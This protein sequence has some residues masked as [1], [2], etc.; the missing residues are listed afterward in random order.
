LQF[1]KHITIKTILKL[2][3]LSTS[4][5]GRAF[6][7]TLLEP[8]NMM[9]F[10]RITLIIF[11]TL[12]SFNLNAGDSTPAYT[13]I[14]LPDYRKTPCPNPDSQGK[15]SYNASGFQGTF[16]YGYFDPITGWGK[17][18][19]CKTPDGNPTYRMHGT[20]FRSDL[21]PP[22]HGFSF[23]GVINKNTDPSKK[24]DV[25]NEFSVF[26][27][28]DQ[29][30]NGNNEFGIVFQDNR[31]EGRFY[32]CKDCNIKKEYGQGKEGEEDLQKWFEW[33]DD[34]GWVD[35]P[36]C[37][38]VYDA[39]KQPGKYQTWNIEVLHDNRFQITMIDGHNSNDHHSCI[40]PK[41]DWTPEIYGSVGYMSVNAKKGSVP[42]NIDFIT[43]G[44]NFNIDNV[45]I[46]ID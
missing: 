38:A 40:L 36:E 28:V 9:N 33:P 31:V 19:K 5:P 44:N 12:V 39:M 37:Q 10:S 4:C 11:V 20:Y 16:P 22:M 13:K 29:C 3:K 23:T 35:G 8:F 34:S 43:E 6:V 42:E 1:F 24:G 46:L 7:K 25:R 17:D 27:H 30:F 26:F 14:D 41:P 18:T 21:L 32:L 45:G 2:D 15:C